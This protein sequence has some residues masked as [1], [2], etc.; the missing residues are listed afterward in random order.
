MINLWKVV[1]HGRMGRGSRRGGEQVGVAAADGGVR[2]CVRRSGKGRTGQG[3]TGCGCGQFWVMIGQG[4]TGL[5]DN[6]LDQGEGH[7]HR[8]II[9]HLNYYTS[10]DIAYAIFLCLPPNRRCPLR[11]SF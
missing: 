4:R 10:V 1:G 9:I 2:T 6:R 11:L 5:V 3:R 7:V 8:C